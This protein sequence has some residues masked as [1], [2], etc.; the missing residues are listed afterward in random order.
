[1][2]ADTATT[3]RSATNAPTRS[4]DLRTR[5]LRPI[6]SFPQSPPGHT[7]RL[8]DRTKLLK[9]RLS[10]VFLLPVWCIQGIQN[11]RPGSQ[12]C[13]CCALEQIVVMR[14][15]TRQTI[16]QLVQD[17]LARF[18]LIAVSNR[19]PYIHEENA[20]RI[21]CR[22][23]ASG[24][25]TALDPIM[26]ASGGVWVA[27]GSGSR[28]RDTVDVYDHVQ[29]PPDNPAYTLR[30]VWLPADIEAGYYY[31][32]ANE[33]LWPLCHAVFHRPRFRP[34]QLGELPP[35][36]TRSFAE[37]VLE[38]ADGEPAF[39]FIQDYHFGLLPRMLKRANPNL[40]IAQFW[41]IPWPNREPSGPSHGRRN[42]ST[43]CSATI[44]SG[45]ICSITART[46][47]RPWTARSRP[48]WITEHATVT[49][50][51]HRTMVR[52]FPISIDFDRHA[53]AADRPE[54]SAEAAHGCCKLG[55]PEYLG[56]GIDRIDYTKGIPERL[57]GIDRF[58]EVHPSY[59]ERL[60]FLQ[61]AVP[62][63]DA[64]DDYRRLNEEV[65]EQVEAIN[66]KWETGGW[67]PI[68]LVH[69][70][71]R[72]ASPD[73][74][75]PDCGLLHCQLA[76]RWHEPGGQGIRR[77]PHRRGRRS[78]PQQ[79]HR[80]RPGIARRAA[81]QPV[82]SGG[83]RVCDQAGSRH[84]RRRATAAHAANANQRRIAQYLP[85]GGEDPGGTLRH[86]LVS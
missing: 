49:R 13:E 68:V 61:V 43:A 59:R 3:S 36:S 62:S 23:P 4:T 5:I 58:L 21:E 28:D 50:G 51:G 80:R 33:A 15:W 60:V 18:P 66:R 22:Q 52:A 10:G 70:H 79:L 12:Y 64:I 67:R 48:S 20:G 71:V 56:I 75:A 38:E 11:A 17:R 84:A 45:S 30:R 47:S 16:H 65:V 27:H 24:M 76:A 57:D 37:A 85:L 77:Q 1:M 82:R 54:V 14:N 19:E 2:M 63:R 35:R 7:A 81:D 32:L 34:M 9:N 83:D 25:A 73:G 6:F 53:A 69:H 86:R 55:R 44:C 41:H 31:G 40:I 74:T 8:Q 46:S 42:C 78:D 29:V 72:P 26:R 39:V